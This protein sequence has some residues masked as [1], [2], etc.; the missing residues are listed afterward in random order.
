[1]QKY[2]YK[3]MDMAYVNDAM[4]VASR[5][6]R[7]TTGVRVLFLLQR[8]RDGGHT[9]NSKL[10]MY[11]TRNSDEWVEAFAKLLQEKDQY[12]DIPLRVYQTLNPRNVKKAI[13][14]F[15]ENQLANDYADNESMENFYIDIK[16]RWVSALM[17][18][19]NKDAAD[20][21]IDVDTEDQ[22]TID[23]VEAAIAELRLGGPITLYKTKKGWHY[24][25]PPFNP[26]LFPKIENVE[27][28]KDPMMLLAY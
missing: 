3:N 5:F 17:K 4:G 19:C 21:L 1:M 23:Q 14:T 12:P 9:N 28:K 2:E 22:A 16:N 6:Q 18:P 26:K 7:F 25:T 8:H 20:F 10:R 13:R 27:L 15:K 24:I 11:I